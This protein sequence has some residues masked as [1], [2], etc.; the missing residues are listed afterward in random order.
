MLVGLIG[1]YLAQI[2]SYSIWIDTVFTV[3]VI[4]VALLAG[5]AHPSFSVD[6]EDIGRKPEE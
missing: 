6:N 3:W 1:L 4:L 2:T 5:A